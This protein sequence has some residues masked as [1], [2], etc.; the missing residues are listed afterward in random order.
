VIYVAYSIATH[1]HV[2]FDTNEK[3]EEIFLENIKRIN[4]M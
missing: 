1:I 3:R 4:S 2:E